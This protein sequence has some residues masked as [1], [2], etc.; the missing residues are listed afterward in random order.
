MNQPK[1][2]DFGLRVKTELLKRGMTQSDLEKQVSKETGLFVDCGYM[3][4]IF[5]GKRTP[6]KVISSICKI[7]SLSEPD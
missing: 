5:T 6:E 7:L 1:L 4:K 3:Y 2:T